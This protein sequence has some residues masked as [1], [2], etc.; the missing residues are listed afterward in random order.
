MEGWEGGIPHCVMSVEPIWPWIMIGCRRGER[1]R[2]FCRPAALRVSEA[3][4]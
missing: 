4:G 2:L 3:E 1:V